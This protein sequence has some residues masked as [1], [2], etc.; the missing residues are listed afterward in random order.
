MAFVKKTLKAHYLKMS[1]RKMLSTLEPPNSVKPLI[2]RHVRLDQWIFHYIKK[3]SLIKVLFEKKLYNF[4]SI[5]L[6]AYTL[7][8]K[9]KGTCGTPIKNAFFW[10][11]VHLCKTNTDKKLS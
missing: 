5:Y 1:T 6:R 9:T 8:I 10:Y 3:P 7:E 2:N 4:R 11:M